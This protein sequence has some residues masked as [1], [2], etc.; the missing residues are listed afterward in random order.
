MESKVKSRALQEFQEATQ[1]LV[2]PALRK[3]KDQGGKVIGCYCS[4]VPEEIITAAGFLPFRMRGTGSTGTDLADT[5][6]S[7]INCSFTR[8]SLD[9]GLRGDYA[10]LDGVVWTSSCDHIRRIYDHWK[11]KINTPYVTLLSLPKK[12]GDPQIEWYAEE[13]RMMRDSMEKHFGVKI[14][15]E[16]LKDAIKLHNE[17]RRLQ[18]KLYDFRRAKN[19]PINGTETLAVMVAG[20]AMPR[21]HYNQVLRGLI[22]ELSSSRDAYND[23]RARIILTGGILDD[24]AYT[25]VIEEQGA[26]IVADVLCFGTRLMWA[27]V[28]E[29]TADPVTALSRFYIHD[30]PQCS[31]MFGDQPVRAAFIR[32]LIEDFKADAVISERLVMCDNWTGE[33]FMTGEDLKEAG[34]PY[35]RLDREYTMAGV[36]QLRTRVQAFLETLGR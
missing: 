20:T 5:R 9:M 3:W 29:N 8:H 16:K 14:T 12:T 4:Y 36:G 21:E 27:D 31:R 18:R 11:R 7:S 33:Q 28:E 35:M 15:D 32:K 10:F 2:N 23:Y 19:P 1:T 17:T 26:L 24:P 6:V 34:I 22:E 25:G 30:R 13:I